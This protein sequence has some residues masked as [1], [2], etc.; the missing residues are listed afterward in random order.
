MTSPSGAGF[1]QGDV[2]TL[3]CAVI[4]AFYIVYLDVFSK[5]CNVT[6][7]AFLQMLVTVSLASAGS[8]SVE[9]RHLVWTPRLV[10]ALGYLSILSTVVTIYL[11][12]RFQKYTTPTRASII[13]SL[14]P[15]FAAT[16]AYYFGNERIG[17]FGLLGGSLI[18]AGLLVS[19]L[20]DLVVSFFKQ[21]DI[22]SEDNV[23][24]PPIND[25]FSGPDDKESGGS[26]P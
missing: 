23:G 6:Q 2:W 14:E 7:L 3:L 20:S 10:L 26:M 19:E 12:T 15:V 11:H 4:F 21:A 22:T 25:S 9:S 1:N 24:P 13:F 16:V 5:V 17:L 8:W 18:V